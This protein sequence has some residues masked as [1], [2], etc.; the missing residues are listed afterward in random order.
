MWGWGIFY[1]FEMQNNLLPINIFIF[2]AYINLL[3]CMCSRMLFF[4]QKPRTGHYYCG[5]TW[6]IICGICSYRLPYCR[7]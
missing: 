2:Y 4:S 3:G 7:G 1:I 6:I 5:C